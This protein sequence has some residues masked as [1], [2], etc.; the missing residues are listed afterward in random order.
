[1]GFIFDSGVAL[2]LFIGFSGLDLTH[3][4]GTIK[5]HRATMSHR[6]PSGNDEP[7]R[8]MMRSDHFPKY[9]RFALN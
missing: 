8:A 9:C 1:M 5:L 6:H 2:V 4:R 3:H 7:H